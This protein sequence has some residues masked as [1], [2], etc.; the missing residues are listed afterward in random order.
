MQAAGTYRVRVCGGGSAG[1][2]RLSP[3]AGN[4]PARAQC[5]CRLPI[6]TGSCLTHTHTHAHH[7]HAKP[8]PP[9]PGPS[10]TPR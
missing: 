1:W 9:P 8:P 4:Q 2:L 6:V 5:W 10:N 3:E 7:T